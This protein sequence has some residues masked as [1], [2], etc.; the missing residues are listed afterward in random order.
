MYPPRPLAIWR[1]NNAEHQFVYRSWRRKTLVVRREQTAHPEVN[2]LQETVNAM[3]HLPFMYPP[4]LSSPS[5]SA[6]I[7]VMWFFSL[8]TCHNTASTSPPFATPSPNMNQW[9]GP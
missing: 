5:N 4:F 3:S 1:S 9:M 8:K 6:C 2:I 7:T